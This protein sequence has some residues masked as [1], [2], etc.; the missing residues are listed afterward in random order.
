M[1]V[2]VPCGLAL[3]V[4]SAEAGTAVLAAPAYVVAPGY[5]GAG[6]VV[7][8]P[9][10]PAPLRRVPPSVGRPGGWRYGYP[11]YGYPAYGYPGWGWGFG[12]GVGWGS[13]PPRPGAG[14]P[15][16]R[17]RPAPG[18]GG[19]APW[20]SPRRSPTA[21]PPPHRLLRLRPLPRRWPRSNLAATGTTAPSPRATTLR[22]P[23]LAAPDRG[24]ADLEM[25]PN[26]ARIA[27]A[28]CSHGFLA[29]C[30]AARADGGRRA[31]TRKVA[32][33]VQRRREQ[34]PAVGECGHRRADAER[35]GQCRGDDR[36]STVPGA[37]VGALFGA[38]TGTSMRRGLGRRA[39]A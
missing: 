34:P 13:R 22:E 2:L 14:R 24:P 18:R 38:A 29:G 9:K 26:A 30:V 17:H 37:A 15:T 31:R 33:T 8:S 3:A 1:R 5:G 27:L 19:P 12:Y 10:P 35:P 4:A 25:T 21:L 6:S 11:A 28:C 39:P 16:T 32:R 23:V 20:V 7:R 36:R